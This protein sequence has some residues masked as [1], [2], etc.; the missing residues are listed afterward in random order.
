[1]PLKVEGF[2]E[3]WSAR[4]VQKK[5]DAF[6]FEIDLHLAPRME[7]PTLVAFELEVQSAATSPKHFAEARMR[8]RPSSGNH[9]LIGRALQEMAPR[10]FDSMRRY[11]H[12]GPEQRSSDRWH[13]PQPLS[14]YPVRP[15][16]EMEEVLDGISRN[17]SLSGVSFRVPRGPNTEFVYLHWYKSPAGSPYAVLARIVRTQ[18]MVGGGY[19]VGAAFSTTV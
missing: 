18:P 1:L 19:E 9:E 17:I 3:E 13:C 2:R 10:L 5:D 6:L 16:L 11:L 8:I 12:A 15:D 7:A 14:V 4:I